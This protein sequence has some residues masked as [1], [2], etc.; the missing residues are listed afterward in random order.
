MRLAVELDAH[1]NNAVKFLCS[2][3][4]AL[5]AYATGT[6]KSLCQIVA[7][8]LLVRKE[9]VDKFI[10]VGTPNS[11]IEIM[12]DYKNL[13]E[14]CPKQLKTVQ[15]IITFLI[16]KDN[17][18][19]V[20]KYSVLDRITSRDVIP[21][22][23]KMKVGVSFD[24]F[25]KLKNRDTGVSKT[26]DQLMPYFTYA[27]G[28]TATA[29][30]SKLEDLYFLIDLLSP[31]YLGTHNQF[32]DAYLDRELKTIYMKGGTRKVWNIRRYKNLTELQERLGGIMITF[33]P[34]YD[35][36]Y[37]KAESELSDY[38][39]YKKA[40]KGVLEVLRKGSKPKEEEE[41]DE[42]TGEPKS[43]SARMCDAQFVVNNDVNK[44]ELFR[45]EIMAQRDRGVLVYCSHHDTVELLT[46]TLN[47]M[48]V[49]CGRITGKTSS[50]NREKTKKWFC[51]A[52][53]NKVLII[54]QGGGQS[55]NLQATNRLI[56]Y[57][58]P[59]GI[60]NYVQVL[61][62]VARYFSNFKTFEITFITMSKTVDEYKMAYI[63][64]N[65]EPIMAVLQNKMGSKLDI[66]S[67]NDYVLSRL[68]QEL[69]WMKKESRK[70]G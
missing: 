69:V 16:T 57:D 40:A 31:G 49:E 59:F 21:Y 34:F 42:D 62:R 43:Y 30:T 41:W 27:F 36:Q 29:I 14:H 1:Q 20:M 19:G 67:Y 24:E 13:G 3:K 55:L 51:S 70:K 60:G 61:G 7:S 35:I 8:M 26:F 25:H 9:K 54:T 5:L 45:Q 68:R 28:A 46:E 63:E 39:P 58:I 66:P 23:E 17:P 22:L 32:V 52:P 56:F 48:G 15:D 64:H 38:E 12:N 11:L 4:R 18:I 10:F 47:E 33:Y 37:R 65:S 2:R 50:P 44:I 6:G 53:Q